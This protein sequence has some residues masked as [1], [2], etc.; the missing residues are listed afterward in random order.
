MISIYSIITLIMS[1]IIF[2]TTLFFIPGFLSG[3]INYT[4]SYLQKTIIQINGYIV[5]DNNLFHFTPYKKFIFK[6]YMKID[7]LGYRN[8]VNNQKDVDIIILGDSLMW[9]QDSRKDLGDLL[10]EKDISAINLG[11]GSYSP[12]HYYMSYKK[13]II[14]NKIKHKKIVMILFPGNDIDDTLR[15][16]YNNLPTRVGPELY[17]LTMSIIYGSYSILKNKIKSWYENKYVKVPKLYTIK[18]PYKTIKIPYLWDIRSFSVDHK[19]KTWEVIKKIN[20]LA[21]ASGAELNIVVLPS[22]ASLYGHKSIAPNV[23]NMNGENLSRMVFYHKDLVKTYD[24]WS[25]KENIKIFDPTEDFAKF[26]LQ[27]FPFVSDSDCHF[28]LKGLRFLSNYL[29]KNGITKF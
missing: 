17:S 23:K 19:A 21:K 22:F 15:F 12:I 7:N 13:N 20:S 8:S 26:T 3:M 27:E 2:I 25:K 6:P 24:Q 14:K 9:A 5:D 4:P 18:L 28:N 1:E 16:P 11:M 29:E 10:R